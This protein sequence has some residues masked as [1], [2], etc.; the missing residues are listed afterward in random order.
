[1]KLDNN[2]RKKVLEEMTNI[3]I[4]NL[5]EKYD[6]D[7]FEVYSNYL[8]NY[9]NI[10]SDVK[11]LKKMTTLFDIGYAALDKTIM[12]YNDIFKRSDRL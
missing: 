9:H 11:F 10:G 3:G 1:M 5:V 7:K 6:L 12:D 2:K 4:N 8:K